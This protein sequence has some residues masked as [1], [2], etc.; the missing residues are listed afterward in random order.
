MYAIIALFDEQTEREIKEVWEGLKQESITSYAF[1][2]PNRQ[3]HITLASYNSLDV[4]GITKLMNH[5]YQT[6][7]VIN[8][9]FNTI[10]TFIQSG[11]LFLEPVFSTEL[12][13]LHS[14]HHRTFEKYNDHP[15]SLYLPNSWIPHCTLANRLTKQK[16]AEAFGYC[17]NMLTPLHGQ[18][19]EVALIEL[20]TPIQVQTLHKVTLEKRKH[21]S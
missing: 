17:I 2:V 7:E 18:I 8:V 13:D 16:M 19:V 5:Y 21:L 3:P 12:R 15:A 20:V 4:E 14:G 10:G 6:S 1:E 11:T 9:T